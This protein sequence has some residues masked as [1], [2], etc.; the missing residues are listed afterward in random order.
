MKKITVVVTV[1]NIEK[2]IETCLMSILSQRYQNIEIIVVNDGSTDLSGQICDRIAQMDMRVRVIHQENQGPIIAR[3]RGVEAA[4]TEYVTFVDGDDWIDENLY[5]DI[6]LSGLLGK[7]DLISFG[8]MRYRGENDVFEEPFAFEQGVYSAEQIRSEMVPKLLWDIEK[9]RYGLDPSLWSKIFT[10]ELLLKHLYRIQELKIH[11]GEDIAVLYPVILDANSIG[12]LNKSYYYHRLRKNGII[13]SYIKDS[14]YYSK[15]FVLYQ[16]LQKT[17]VEK[18]SASLLKQLDY[19]YMY[20]I[21]LAKIRY[22]N[23]V[24]ESQFLFPFDKVPKGSR[25]VLYGAG[26]M[27]QTFHKQLGKLDFCKVVAWVDRGHLAYSHLG[28]KEVDVLYELD[29]DYVLIAIQAKETSN[30][31]TDVLVKMGISRDKIIRL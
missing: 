28:V 14:D 2:Y 4:E 8:I 26:Q 20:S 21:E 31:V 25:L 27:G 11:Y 5:Q 1:Y 13:P 29:F 10:K 24:F 17:F 15:L 16:Y 22:G 19:F 7:V 23:L 9:N 6:A 18:K 3:L 30:I 12:I